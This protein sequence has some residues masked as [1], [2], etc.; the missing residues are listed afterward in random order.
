[1]KPTLLKVPHPE[2]TVCNCHEEKGFLEVATLLNKSAGDEV[3]LIRRGL[4]VCNYHEKTSFQE[5]AK[6]WSK[7]AVEEDTLTRKNPKVYICCK[8]K[9]SRRGKAME[10]VRH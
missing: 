6:Q 5:V 7:S 9:L 4:Q 1:M 2:L 10:Q 8:D 3:T